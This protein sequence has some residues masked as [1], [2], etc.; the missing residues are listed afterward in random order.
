MT[1]RIQESYCDLMYTCRVIYW[2]S[3]A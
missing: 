2:C 1:V 3:I